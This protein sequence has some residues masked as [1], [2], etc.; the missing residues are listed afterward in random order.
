MAISPGSGDPQRTRRIHNHHFDSRR[1]DHVALRDDDIVIASPY[2][3]GTTWLQAIVAHLVFD[4][5]LAAPL[6]DLS[7]WLEANYHDLDALVLTLEQQ[8]H[9]RF[10]KSHLPSMP[11][12]GIPGGVFSTSPAMEGMWRCRFGIT[13]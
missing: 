6:A 8:R 10:I 4:G 9:R 13:T 2:K 1:W 3:S 5:E 12:H 7:P 11:C